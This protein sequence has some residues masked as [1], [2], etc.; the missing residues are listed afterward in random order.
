M[1][2]HPASVSTFIAFYD[3]FMVLLLHVP[4]LITD[5]A[6]ESRISQ[7]FHKSLLLFL[8]VFLFT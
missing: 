2:G 1:I 5:Y 6:D 4:V 7:M 3:L 8:L